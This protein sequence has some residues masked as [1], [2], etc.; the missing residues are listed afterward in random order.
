MITAEKFEAHRQASIDRIR[1][2]IDELTSVATQ[3]AN[4]SLDK[5]AAGE[6][7]LFGFASGGRDGEWITK[8][9]LCD[10]RTYGYD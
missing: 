1:R 10:Y 2:E 3:L 6:H 7:V 4:H 5:C 9:R 8:C